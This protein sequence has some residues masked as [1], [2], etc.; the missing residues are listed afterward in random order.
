MSAGADRG[1][2]AGSEDSQAGLPKRVPAA[3]L[4]DNGDGGGGLTRRATVRIEDN[5]V[6]APAASQGAQVSQTPHEAR[7]S[8][9]TGTE[10]G[11][12]APPAFHR[13]WSSPTPP[14]EETD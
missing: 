8:A 10:P 13:M 14:G 12:A 3:T 2:I 7:Q 1:V 6:T 4:G 11:Q 5:P 9:A